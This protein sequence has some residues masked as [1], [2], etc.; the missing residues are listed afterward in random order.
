MSIWN[1]SF[2]QLRVG[3]CVDPF[4]AVDPPPPL[5]AL[6]AYINQLQ[7]ELSGAL[8]QLCYSH[9]SYIVM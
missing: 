4:K 5:S 3:T 8:F 6:P 9:Q 7:L 2:D 1:I